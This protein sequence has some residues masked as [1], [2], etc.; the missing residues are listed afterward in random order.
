MEEPTFRVV[1]GSA[2][3][4]PSESLERTFLRR[5]VV[6]LP[7]LMSLVVVGLV[8]A[9]SG[10]WGARGAA[11]GRAGALSE[12]GWGEIRAASLAADAK[13]MRSLADMDRAAASRP[14]ISLGRSSRETLRGA[15]GA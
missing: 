12:R 1:V 6:V 15:R 3:D 8:A 7:A 4:P 14:A 10:N 9:A 5:G 11:G 2:R 13:M